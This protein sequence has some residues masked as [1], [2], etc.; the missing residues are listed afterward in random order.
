MT[1]NNVAHVIQDPGQD[2]GLFLDRSLFQAQLHVNFSGY[3]G[4]TDHVTQYP[5]DG[6]LCLKI[7][8]LVH[9]LANPSQGCRI[10]AHFDIIVV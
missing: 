3:L 7:L 10:Q 6:G 5:P 2:L 8:D 1:A 4:I 9:I